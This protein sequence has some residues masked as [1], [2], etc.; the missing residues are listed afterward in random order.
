[1]RITRVSAIRWRIPNYRGRT[2]VCRMSGGALIEVEAPRSSNWSVSIWRKAD[3]ERIR[4]M[5]V[6]ETID[7]GGETP[8]P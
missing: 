8:C 4:A 1:M 3:V 7:L 2:A 6:G 5:K